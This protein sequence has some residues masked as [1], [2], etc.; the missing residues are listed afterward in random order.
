[1]QLSFSNK[2]IQNKIRHKNLYFEYQNILNNNFILIPI[3]SLKSDYIND[4]RN[5][6]NKYFY[7]ILL[8]KLSF[9]KDIGL[10]GQFLIIFNLNNKININEINF[11]LN[12]FL[13]NNLKLIYYYNIYQNKYIIENY[14]NIENTLVYL[15][16]INNNFTLLIII[17]NI[18]NS[19]IRLLLIYVNK[20]IYIIH[21]IKSNA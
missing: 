19:F 21:N 15:K 7:K 2:L 11:F 13:N 14:Y 8:L 6:L 10:F 3:I 1:M 9:L 17:E 5:K 16:N 4:L 12:I 20:L 18:L